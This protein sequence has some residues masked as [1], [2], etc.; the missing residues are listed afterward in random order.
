MWEEVNRKL[1][2]WGGGGKD[3]KDTNE[4]ETVIATG[5]HIVNHTL[6]LSWATLGIFHLRS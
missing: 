6:Y 1:Q 3:V 4:R 5:C 2:S